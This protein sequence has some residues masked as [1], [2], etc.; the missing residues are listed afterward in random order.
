M[1]TDHEYASLA[2]IDV[3]KKGGNAADAAIASAAALA[4]LDPYM[5]GLGG[6]GYLLYY[7][8]IPTYASNPTIC[9]RILPIFFSVLVP[10]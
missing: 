2:G 3:M 10:N 4:A 7:D 8:A 1:S 5:A 6:Y 9:T